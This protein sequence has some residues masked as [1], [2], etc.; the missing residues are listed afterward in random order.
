MLLYA[1]K[2]LVARR[3]GAAKASVARLLCLCS[4][5][6]EARSWTAA[7]LCARAL[8]DDAGKGGAMASRELDCSYI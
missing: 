6:A 5:A 8:L 4:A 2:G 7:A 1:R 3:V